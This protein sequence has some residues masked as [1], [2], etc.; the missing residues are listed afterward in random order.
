MFGDAVVNEKAF[1]TFLKFSREG[2]RVL[3]CFRKQ[4]GG[5]AP[6][7]A[8][9]ANG[10][11]DFGF[12]IVFFFDLFSPDTKRGCLLA[13]LAISLAS[14]FSLRV[15]KGWHGVPHTNTSTSAIA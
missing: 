3:S 13:A 7:F 9:G 8:V 10:A 15:E 6:D 14:D 11:V 1:K 4:R 12:Q 5:L 2:N